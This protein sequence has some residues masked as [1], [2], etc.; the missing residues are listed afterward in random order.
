MATSDA[1]ASLSRGPGSTGWARHPIFCND[2]PGF[3]SNRVLMP[4][5]NKAMTLSAE[6]RWRSCQ[7]TMDS[8][9][10]L[11]IVLRWAR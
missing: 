9:M 8:I 1:T 2:Y 7:N 10:K 6:E 11:G 3:V 4:I 5:I